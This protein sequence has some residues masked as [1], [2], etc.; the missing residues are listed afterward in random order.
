[1]G[2]EYAFITLALLIHVKNPQRGRMIIKLQSN[3]HKAETR[4]NGKRTPV[5][6]KWFSDIGIKDVAEVGGKNASLG[7]MYRELAPL[8]IPVPN[9]FAVTAA[10]YRHLLDIAD[11]WSRLDEIMAGIQLDNGETL[12]LAAKRA[13]EL[14]YETG[15]PDEM[16][17]E[18]LSAYREL[19]QHYDSHVSL[20]VRS[21]ATAEDLPTAS[22]AGQHESFL[23]VVGEEALLDACRRCF[24]SLFTER[25]ITYRISQGF[26]YRQ[27]ALS[28]GVMKMVRSDLAASGV[29][30]T[31]DTESGFREVV[32]ITAAYGLGENIVQGSVDPDEFYVHKPTWEQGYR[33]VLRRVRGEK[34]IRMIYATTPG[35][36]STV[37]VDVEHES[38]QRY[39]ISDEHVLA[40]AGY[41]IKLEQH[42]SKLTA[43]MAAARLG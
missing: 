16:R 1:M 32:F 31:M 40:L 12:A 28:V 19:Q 6:V 38:R 34:A 5:Y 10:A 18:I 9:G 29:M 8:G 36:R 42:Y 24:A 43:T 39:C 30:F 14:V 3:L 26:D 37:N 4:M 21:S 25:A 17:D 20:A 15:I 35:G 11:G 23:N 7:E 22:F 41:A 27:V 2:K 33:C 13:R